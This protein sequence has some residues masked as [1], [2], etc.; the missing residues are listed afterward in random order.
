M[1]GKTTVVIKKKKAK[2]TQSI[3]LEIDRDL[4]HEVGV[5]AAEKI[6]FKREIVE[7]ALTEYIRKEQSKNDNS[8]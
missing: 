8:R 6:L 2:K 7:L 4:W 3:N 1:A 5:I